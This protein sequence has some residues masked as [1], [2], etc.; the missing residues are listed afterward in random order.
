MGMSD[1]R[2][3]RSMEV[4]VR[5]DGRGEQRSNSLLDREISG[6]GRFKGVVID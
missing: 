6:M 4:F 2:F 1:V 3:C 5:K